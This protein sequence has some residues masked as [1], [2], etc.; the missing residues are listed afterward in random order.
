MT[1]KCSQ[2]G[3]RWEEPLP[4][5]EPCPECGEPLSKPRRERAEEEERPSRPKRRPV[6]LTILLGILAVGFVGC[7]GLIGVLY[8]FS[9]YPV[10][11]LDASRADSGQGGTSSVSATLRIADSGRGFGG[12]IILHARAGDRATVQH[13]RIIGPGG[14]DLKIT[15]PTRELI[16]QSGPVEFWVEREE[17]G[18]IS[19]VSEIRTIP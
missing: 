15:L 13:Y 14:G 1:R 17:R 3:A 2:C 11:I 16:S 4:D 8:L 7:A 9:S 6:L 18:K 12:E 5:G 10:K 19:R